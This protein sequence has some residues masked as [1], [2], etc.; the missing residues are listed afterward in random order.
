MPTLYVD[1]LNLSLWFT[2]GETVL[3]ILQRGGIL[4]ESPCGGQGVCGQCTIRVQEP[5]SVPE[6]PHENIADRDGARGL[7]LACRLKPDQDLRIHLLDD[8]RTGAQTLQAGSFVVE[9]GPLPV[10]RPSP[11]VHLE[12]HDHVCWLQYAG[13]ADW[14]KLA[15][16]EAGL[17]PKGL[18]IDLGTTTLVLSLLSLHSGEEL[19]TASG[20]NPQIAFGHD[21]M[22]R[23]HHG[24]SPE[25]LNA[26]SGAIQEA[27][28]EL[29]VEVCAQS[30]SQPLEILDVVLGGNTSMLQLLAGIDPSPLGRDPFQVSIA[31]G[32]SYPAA[33][34][35]LQINPGA[36]VYLPPVLHAFVGTDISAGLLLCEGFFDDEAK[37]LFL[38]V[39]TNGEMVLNIQGRRVA[40]S[41]AAGPVFEGAGLSSGM[42]AGEGAVEAVSLADGDLGLSSIGKGP[43]K[44]ICGS[45]LL[46][47]VAVL[48]YVG[49]LEPSGRMLE[50]SEKEK[51]PE[52]LR[53]RLLS[54]SDIPAFELA[55]GVTFTQRDVRQVQL[56]KGAVRAGIDLLLQETG[57]P[58]GHLD[59]IVIGG[60]FGHF[61]RPSSLEAIGLIPPNT[62]QKIV[63]AGNTS[64]NGC[65]RLLVDT[66]ARKVLEA[67]MQSVEHLSIAEL[68]AFMDVYLRSMHLG[69]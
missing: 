44:G 34:F 18:A 26:L 60:G 51:V 38:D 59:R 39:G 65:A 30:G 66:S 9:G 27:L 48:G 2:P 17:I 56:A 43:I 61:L 24:S 37:V 3:E 8:S 57:C 6:T 64:R 41:T 50:P 29:I 31:G 32:T 40:T 62:R 35:G 49:V 11:A 5:E 68:P 21:V 42:R 33:D 45:G 23:I 63:F 58:P 67:N 19:A 15:V 20:L 55:P 69:A 52:K 12:Y 14:E 16:W 36:R 7:R 4:I 47:L 46:D 10:S 28:N 54:F 13:R 22:T 1:P 53:D 25:G